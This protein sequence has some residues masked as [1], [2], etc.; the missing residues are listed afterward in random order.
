MDQA[1]FDR[2]Y[3]DADYLGVSKYRRNALLKM[4]S[5][6]GYIEGVSCVKRLLGVKIDRNVCITLKGLEYLE[7]NMTLKR[8]EQLMSDVKA[9]NPFS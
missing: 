6:N 5:D 4:L 1:E 7:N 9:L 2:R 3:L 8:A